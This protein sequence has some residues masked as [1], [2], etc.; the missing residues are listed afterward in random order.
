MWFSVWKSAINEQKY[1]HTQLDTYYGSI[2]GCLDGQT[3]L[4][5]HCVRQPVAVPIWPGGTDGPA[6]KDSSC[7][8]QCPKQFPNRCLTGDAEELTDLIAQQPC[9]SAQGDVCHSFHRSLR[10]SL[11]FS[12]HF[13]CLTRG[14]G[15]LT[16]ISATGCAVRIEFRGSI[17]ESAELC[18]T[19]CRVSMFIEP[20][21]CLAGSGR[22]TNKSL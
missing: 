13:S 1:R 2:D 11:H 22:P 12:L 6:Y 16:R 7:V 17:T 10:F 5:F 4:P 19:G 21:F 14:M 9:Q 8:K 18:W 3:T 15:E 20:F